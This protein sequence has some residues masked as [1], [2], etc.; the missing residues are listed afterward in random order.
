MKH[1]WKILFL[2]FA[3]LF[4]FNDNVNSQNYFPADP[5]FLIDHEKKQFNGL[6]QLQPNIFRPIFAPSDSLSFTAII[7]NEN[8]YNTNAPNQ[9]NMDIRYF[10]KGSASFTSFQLSINSPYLLFI[11]E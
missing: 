2:K 5:Y 8:Y 6:L 1:L 9:E 3:V 4:T 7:R 11:M 10:S